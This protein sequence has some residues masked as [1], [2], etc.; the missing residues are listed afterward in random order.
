MLVNYILNRKKGVREEEYREEKS[1]SGQEHPM[2]IFQ[3]SE[4][5]TKNKCPIELSVSLFLSYEQIC[6]TVKNTEAIHYYRS[7]G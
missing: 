1:N 3:N 7:D 2:E 5:R 4:D 6:T